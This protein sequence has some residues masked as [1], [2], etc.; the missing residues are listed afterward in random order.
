[1]ATLDTEIRVECNN[2]ISYRQFEKPT[3]TNTVLMKRSAL[4][5]NA[6]I[7]ILSNELARRL[8]NTDERQD[9]RI[10]GGVVDKFCQKLLTS[11]YSFSQTK[12]IT[13][14]GIR[15]W[16]RRKIR[17]R[18]ERGRLFRTSEESRGGRIKK[19][20]TGRNNWFRKKKKTST[21]Q[22]KMSYDKEVSSRTGM[23]PSPKVEG[24]GESTNSK[25]D[26]RIAAVMFVENT[27][28]GVLAKNLREVVER[29]K[30][31]L[32][33]RVK[34]VE[35]AGTPLKLMFPLSKVG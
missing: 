19:K 33:Y 1:M 28:G 25:E 31:I 16:E 21:A 32:G 14:C 8:G 6:N 2:I 3:T 24:R 29:I 17:A 4:E 26:A 15:G 20:T 10:V 7:Q 9:R 11:G 23:K 13:L 30:G 18:S 35:R 27:K 5:E 12:K 22:G 34:I